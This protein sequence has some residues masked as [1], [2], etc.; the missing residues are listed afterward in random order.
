[1][2]SAPTSVEAGGWNYADLWE[3]V[4][5]ATPARLAQVSG[6]RR[7]T[8]HQFDRGADGVAQTLVNGGLGQQDKV[9]LYLRNG[10]EYLETVFATL[11]AGLVPV[12]TNYRYVERELEYLWTN[13]DVVAVVFHGS[14]SPLVD[15]V[16]RRMPHITTWIHVDDGTVPCPEWAVSY[17][18]ARESTRERFRAPW[19]RSGDDLI[20]IYTGGTT[21]MPKGVMWR[22]HD[23]ILAS[24][25]GESGFASDLQAVRARV[26]GRTSSLVGV[27]AAPLM[28]GTAFVF[29]T[30]LLNAGG[31][32]ATL[33]SRSFD[34]EELLDLIEDQQVRSICIVGDAFCRMLIEALDRHPGRWP[35]ESL[36]VVTSA[37][38]MWSPALKQRLHA[39]APKARFIDFLN[40]SEASGMGRLVT[41][42][43]GVTQ[44][45]RFRLGANAV[46]ID[47]QGVLVREPGDVGQ[48]AVRGHLPLGYYKDHV[49]TDATF[50]TVDGERYSVPGDHARLMEDGSIT[51]LGRGSSSI[52]TGGEKVYPEEVEQAL[53]EHPEVRDAVVIGMPD[54]RFG[55]QVVAA[56]QAAAVIDSAQLRDFA[57]ERLAGYKVP[58]TIVQVDSVARG[59]NGK[60]DLSAV[61]EQLR[62][63]MSARA[64]RPGD[65]QVA[66][67]EQPTESKG[68]RG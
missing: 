23:L 28:H 5:D 29:A 58:R 13:A 44:A 10:I 66:G 62:A 63:R 56:V 18:S 19:G 38:A 1:M 17:V 49:A 59:P 14:Y 30:T 3:A 47:E 36:R 40:S 22:Q 42:A 25:A 26:V 11:K 46:L 53:K 61:R 2:S 45:A 12:N 16:R 54:P 31:T 48:I 9:A 41:D 34:A 51:L 35:L 37:G 6:L 43:G 15:E 20:L 50:R 33:A 32:V 55:E 39:H 65:R 60:T 4:A 21:G 64:A 7:Q 8:W 67:N 52:N 68:R 27:P 24:N 57:R